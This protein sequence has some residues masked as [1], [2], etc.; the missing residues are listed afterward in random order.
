MLP[1]RVHNYALQSLAGSPDVF[2]ALTRG[3]TDEEADRRP[4]PAR[5]TIREAIAHLADWEGVFLKRM[6]D[7][8]DTD[9]AT[10]QGYDEGQWAIDHDYAHSDWQTE[11]ERF[12]EGRARCLEFLRALSPAQRARIGQHTE[13][14]P[15]TLEE[16]MLLMTVHDG[17]HLAQVAQWR[18]G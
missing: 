11:L 10:L 17:Y 18:A 12:R 5:F 14:G 7:T 4:D 3:M 1:E 8:R 9:N 13:A 15:I 2:L 6:T 16:Q